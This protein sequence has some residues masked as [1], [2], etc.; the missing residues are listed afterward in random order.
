MIATTLLVDSAITQVSREPAARH[1][2]RRSAHGPDVFPDHRLR[3]DLDTVP[4]TALY[5]LARLQIV[6]LLASVP[7]CTL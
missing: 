2:F 3:A 5:D 4:Q 7:A 6:P 1:Q